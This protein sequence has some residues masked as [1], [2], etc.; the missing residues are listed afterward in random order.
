MIGAEE[1]G[2]CNIIKA[3]RLGAVYH[4]AA[5]C[6]TLINDTNDEMEV[7]VLLAYGLTSS[8][9]TIAGG[10]VEAVVLMGRVGVS[11]GWDVHAA[12]GLLHSVGGR[13]SEMEA[14][15]KAALVF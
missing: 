4:F 1:T 9:A 2:G 7:Y 11:V 14:A 13:V 6:W 12:G 3:G 8:G 15:L 10:H 5:V